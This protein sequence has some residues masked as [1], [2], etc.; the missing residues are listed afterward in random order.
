MPREINLTK[1]TSLRAKGLLDLPTCLDKSLLIEIW[2]FFCCL[3]DGQG[4]FSWR[5]ISSVEK[6]KKVNFKYMYKICD[7]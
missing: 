2:N 6:L 7:Q 1:P 3:Y 4:H 5:N